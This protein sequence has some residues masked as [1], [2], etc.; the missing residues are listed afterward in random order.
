MSGTRGGSGDPG[1]PRRQRDQRATHE[2]RSEH[3]RGGRSSD[4]PD[5]PDHARGDEVAHRRLGTGKSVRRDERQLPIVTKALTE[6]LPRLVK[7]C[8][9]LLIPY[10]RDVGD[11]SYAMGHRGIAADRPPVTSELGANGPFLTTHSD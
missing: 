4:R 11:D 5:E 1:A 7:L 6:E 9:N 3:E 8:H 10:G 2:Q